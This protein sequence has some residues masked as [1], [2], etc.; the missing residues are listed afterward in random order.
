[1]TLTLR[2]V[3][4]A[5]LTVTELDANFIEVDRR[6]AFLESAGFTNPIT[7]IETTPGTTSLT[8]LFIDGTSVTVPIP[9]LT[10]R[11]R[12]DWTANV[13][14]VQLDTFKVDLVGLYLVLIDHQTASVFDENATDGGGNPL[15]YKLFAFSQNTARYIIG[16]SVPG[17]MGA[18][19]NLLFHCFTAP[20]TIAADFAPYLTHHSRAG[21]SVAATASTAISVARAANSTPT[22]FSSV[23]SI[24]IA[25]GSITPT[26]STSGSTLLFA[27]GDVLRLRGP[28]SPDLSLADFY[29]TIVGHETP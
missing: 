4:G 1:M 24:T 7:G 15:Y 3:K 17:L 13:G 12:G 21:G 26:F 25:A 14:M 20:V 6:V 8:F 10:F 16:C 9:I 27:G 11:W 2:S 18:D 23:G 29:A 22:S 19:Q 28:A 5:P